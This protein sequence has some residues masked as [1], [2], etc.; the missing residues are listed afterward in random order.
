MMVSSGGT[1]QEPDLFPDAVV[2]CSWLEAEV[3]ASGA[4][5][6]CLRLLEPQDL[7]PSDGDR[8]TQPP[9]LNH[10]PVSPLQGDR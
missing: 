8:K 4:D 3:P 6:D 9:C 2:K 7:L 1:T 10:H 5:V